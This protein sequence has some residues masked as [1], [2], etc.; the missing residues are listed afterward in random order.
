MSEKCTNKNHEIYIYIYN[1]PNVQCN[2]KIISFE[3][4]KV[5][6]WIKVILESNCSYLLRLVCRLTY[7][8]KNK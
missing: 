5:C 8:N 6:E 4:Q 7:K 2:V 3:M 1:I